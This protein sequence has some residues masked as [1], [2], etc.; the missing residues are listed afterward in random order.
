MD[1]SSAMDSQLLMHTL[2]D[3]VGTGHCLQNRRVRVRTLEG[4]SLEVDV[5]QS[6]CNMVSDQNLLRCSVILYVDETLLRCS[7]ILDVGR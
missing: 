1:I 7:V 3:P 5:A 2:H 6:P 4:L